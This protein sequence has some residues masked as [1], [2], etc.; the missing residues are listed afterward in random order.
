MNDSKEILYGGAAG[1]KVQLMAAL[2]F[3]DIPGYSAILFRKTYADL[4]L[5]G[6][7]IDMF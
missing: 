3:V 6:A 2:Q 7:L 1:G 5:P 4:S